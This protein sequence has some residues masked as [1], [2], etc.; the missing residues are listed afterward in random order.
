MCFCRSLGFS[1]FPSPTISS[2]C[3]VI[4]ALYSVHVYSVRVRQR[5][6]GACIS[7]SEVPAL[8]NCIPFGRGRMH[9]MACTLHNIVEVRTKARVLPLPHL[10][11]MALP[12]TVS[13][14]SKPPKTRARRGSGVFC[15]RVNPY[16]YPVFRRAVLAVSEMRIHVV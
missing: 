4:S 10:L 11:N 13:T 14:Y 15:C 1:E 6:M 8:E 5:V 12:P 9:E 7:D 3:N 2:V 16:T